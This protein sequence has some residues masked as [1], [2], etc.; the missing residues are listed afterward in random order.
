MATTVAFDARAR[1]QY[2]L[3]LLF[4]MITDSIIQILTM[5]L[6]AP[7]D[8]N[9]KFLKYFFIIIG[10]GLGYYSVFFCLRY[11]QKAICRAAVAVLAF[12]KIVIGAV[13]IWWYPQTDY[14]VSPI[15][16]AFISL[17]SLLCSIALLLY[18]AFYHRVQRYVVRH[19]HLK[20][21][22]YVKRL[23]SGRGELPVEYPARIVIGQVMT[24]MAVYMMSIYLTPLVISTLRLIEDPDAGE[25]PPE[26]LMF[27]TA[28]MITVPAAG[29]MYGWTQSYL[30]LQ[31]CAEHIRAV[32]RGKLRK[33]YGARDAINYAGYQ[34]VYGVFSTIMIMVVYIGVCALVRYLFILG[35]IWEFIWNVLLARYI[36]VPFITFIVA[37]MAREMIAKYVFSAEGYNPLHPRWFEFF[38]YMLVFVNILLATFSYFTT[39]II[40]PLLSIVFFSQRMDWRHSRMDSGFKSY[41]AV[42]VADNE[43]NNMVMRAFI[44]L[45]WIGIKRGQR[46]RS[47]CSEEELEGLELKRRT[48]IARLRWFKAYTII[49]NPGLVH[50]Q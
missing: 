26:Y 46:L 19:H 3:I 22:E 49:R 12:A 8:Q 50:T 5:F 29:I 36:G 31:N 47:S 11:M 15:G 33:R 17:P 18:A 42:I 21:E 23:L 38:E 13:F 20:A 28:M 4:G 30:S 14:M 16:Y 25:L 1:A 48:N 7:E 39:R 9:Y 2:G 6:Y 40:L 45:L 10:A 41:Y 35:I 43:K 32:R 37:K 34:V 24:V 44:N 27:E